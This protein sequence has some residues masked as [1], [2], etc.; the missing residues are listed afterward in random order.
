[1]L[2]SRS[3]LTMCLPCCKVRFDVR[4]PFFFFWLLPLLPRPNPLFVYL[5][6]V[7]FSLFLCGSFLFYPIYIYFFSPFVTSCMI[8]LFHISQ[9]TQDQVAKSYSKMPPQVETMQ[10]CRGG[11]RV[12]EEG[13]FTCGVF[14]PITNSKKHPNR[15]TQCQ[16][17]KTGA[18]RSNR[19][20]VGTLEVTPN[21]PKKAVRKPGKPGKPANSGG[22]PVNGGVGCGTL[23]GP[24]SVPHPTP[25]ITGLPPEVAGFPSFP[26]FPGLR[27]PFLETVGGDLERPNPS[28]V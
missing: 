7:S 14:C 5:A 9:T 10:N 18:N 27:T 13:S 16:T 11:T 23:G 15:E 25:G 1:M 6:F 3:F 20:G 2:C 21:C 28:P 19:G 8:F 17:G 4:C 24:P 22:K 12:I 26:G